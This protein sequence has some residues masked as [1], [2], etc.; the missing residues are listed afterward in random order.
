MNYRI[1]YISIKFKVH[2]IINTNGGAAFDPLTPTLIK[3]LNLSHSHQKEHKKLGVY[4][5]SR[6]RKNYYR[7]VIA[8]LTEFGTIWSQPAAPGLNQNII[9]KVSKRP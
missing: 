1:V 6:Q 5:Y 7:S 2:L 4:S 3:I 8:S 9:R